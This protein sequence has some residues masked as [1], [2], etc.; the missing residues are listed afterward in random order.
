MTM[1][2]SFEEFI[3]TDLM[4]RHAAS[5]P[6]RTIIRYKREKGGSYEDLSWQS[7][8][9][10]VTCCAAGF[11]KLGLEP[12]DKVCIL[13][14][15]RLEWIIADLGIMAACGVNVPI[16]H[17]NT[18]EQCAYI[19]NDSNA[20]IVVVENREQLDKI[21]NAFPDLLQR[22]KIIVID[23]KTEED[24]ISFA[25]LLETGRAS[26]AE[27]SNVIA[28]RRKR[29]KPG[30]LATIVYTSGTTGPPKG[31]MM[32]HLNISHVLNSI[33]RLIRIDSQK[34]LCLLVL[35]L[36]HFY[37]RVSGYYYNIFRNV[38]LALA[39]SIDTLAKN[40][41]EV[42]PT[43]FCGVPRIFE[44]MY[45][46]IVGTASNGP[47]FKRLIFALAMQTG[48]SRSKRLNAHK[49]LPLWLGLTWKAADSIVFGK[50]RNGLGGRL[51]FAVS[52]GAPLSAEIGE[53]VHSI[54]IQVIEFYGLSETIG[55]TM[56]TFEECRYGTVGK[57]MP[58]FEV[59]LA[60]DGEILIRGNNFLG[61]H[62]RPDLTEDSMQD[63]WFLTGDVGKWDEDG[64]LIITD[65]KKD[66]IITSGGKNISPQNIENSLKISSFIEQAAVIGDNR[67]YLTALIVPAFHELK[68]WAAAHGIEADSMR[69]L[70]AKPEV[71]ALFED[72]VRK[73]TEHLGRVEKIKKFTLLEKEWSQETDELTPTL[74]LKRNVINK[75]YEKEIESMYSD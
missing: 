38:P 68:K 35:P 41:A 12:G 1:T 58:G 30:D 33:D 23:G 49:P 18:P 59:E 43:Y 45:A 62:N 60:P 40:M 2:K 56:T 52:A 36:S 42:K 61:Y 16:Y 31:C 66:L 25:A 10:M 29:V 51:E 20:G 5:N 34:G 7:L 48:R 57:A 65:R 37:P 24:V 69:N 39:E 22:P 74:K 13:S 21:K 64:F 53:F 46:R 67:N 17:T 9:D 75:R 44:K 71:K 19:I 14:Y 4:D 28:E 11:V 63:G 55:G 70:L 32:S 27:V 50:I 72:E 26:L 54:G 15:N 6:H 8:K 3:L 47:F 73:S